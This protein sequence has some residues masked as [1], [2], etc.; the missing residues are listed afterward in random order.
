MHVHMHIYIDCHSFFHSYL[1]KH[2]LAGWF[3]AKDLVT[4]DNEDS[5]LHLILLL[6]DPPTEV[7]ITIIIVLS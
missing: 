1:S 2:Y 5:F 7:H 6:L 4:G 3:H